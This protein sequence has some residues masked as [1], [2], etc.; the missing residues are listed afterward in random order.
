MV[1]KLRIVYY[2]ARR[3]KYVLSI[4]SRGIGW[5]SLDYSTPSNLH[6]NHLIILKESE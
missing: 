4:S 6:P 3:S 2:V 5:L 1:E